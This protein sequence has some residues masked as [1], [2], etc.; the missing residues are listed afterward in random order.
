MAGYFIRNDDDDYSD[1][2]SAINLIAK[3]GQERKHIKAPDSLIPTIERIQNAGYDSDDP[4]KCPPIWFELRENLI[5]ELSEISDEHGLEHWAVGIL[6]DPLGDAPEDEIYWY[7]YATNND[8]TWGELVAYAEEHN[9]EGGL[10]LSENEEEDW[11]WPRAWAIYRGNAKK[12]IRCISDDTQSMLSLD[13]Q[14]QLIRAIKE[15][16]K[17]KEG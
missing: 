1:F 17:G 5:E 15:H 10:Y 4:R 3:I 2:W 16:Q 14:C 6:P 7:A 11:Y 8:V 9:M 13:H 12:I